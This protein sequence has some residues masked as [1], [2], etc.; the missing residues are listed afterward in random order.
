M[1]AT[2]ANKNGVRYLYYVAHAVLRKHSPGPLSRVPAPE[3]EA[4]VVEAIRR[5][6]KGGSTDPR[7]IPE[8]DREL[9]ARHLLRVTLNANEVLLHLR[10]DVAGNGPAVGQ[11]ESFERGK[12]TIAI[13]WAAPVVTPVKGIAHV[14]AYN[15]PMKPGS[16]ELIAI[17]KARKWIQEVEHGHSFADIAHRDGKAER[18][19]RH[20]APLGLVSPRIVAAIIDGTIPAGLTVT[21]L[22]RRLPYSWAKQEEWISTRQ[23]SG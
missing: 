9:I 3:L 19:I 11:D 23:Y 10:Q 15:T 1:S 4:T 12:T 5:H 13:P 20:L 7:S 8:T 18:H 22:A 16:R 6:L 21:A 17:A 2:H 14:P